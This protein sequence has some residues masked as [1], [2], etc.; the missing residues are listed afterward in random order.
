MKKYYPE[1]CLID[2][3][4]NINSIKTPS[5]LQ[6]AMLHG[7]ILEARAIV[8]DNE[9]N[10]I[11]D[12]P[13]MKGFIPRIEGAIGIDNGTTRDIA[14]ISKVNKPVCFKVINIVKDENDN[15]LAILSR[16]AVQEECFENYLSKL[17]SGSIISAKVTH[18]E[19]FGC[20]VD[21]GCGVPSL[22]PIDAIS[23]S[24]I[25][26]PSDRFTV[27]QDIKVIIKSVDNE[28][29]WLSHKELLGTWEENA[30]LFNA[31]ET[32]A[33]IVRSIESY[34]IFIELSPNLAGLAEPKENVNVGQ[35][36]SVYI[37]ALIP[38]KMKVKL[39]VVDVF[40]ANYTNKEL[41]YF[42]SSDKID[43]WKYTTE[44]AEKI[45]ETKFTT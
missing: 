22:I 3:A 19:Q 26:H 31:G 8:C 6:D 30:A 43:H 45:I 20:F 15:P 41:K 24:R 35:H 27:G 10:L 2:T 14:L 34:G 37:K 9:H 42:V 36:A 16:R 23:V 32:V 17:Q 13:C 18:L 12:L 28:R 39:I 33:G 40:D 5:A 4:E 29:I 1:G 25:S 21:V 38:E 44:D 7:K 11:V